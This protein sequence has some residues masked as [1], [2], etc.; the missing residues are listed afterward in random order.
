MAFVNIYSEIAGHV[1]EIPIDLT[2]TL[3]NRAWRDVR[4]KNLWSFLMFEGNWTSPALVNGGTVATTQGRNIVVFDAT[5]TAAINAIFTGGNVPSPVTQR[6]FRIGV[7][8]IY[9]IWAWDG[10]GNATI[11]RPYQEPTA[12]SQTYMIFQCYYYS[13]VMDFWQWI[14]VRDMTN[15]NDLITTK[16]RSEIDAKDPQRTVYYIPTHVV[17]YQQN[18]NPASNQYGI[19]MFE[20]WGV[21]QYVLTYQLYGLRKG[22]PL[23]NDSDTLPPQ[24]GEDCVIELG[25]AKAYEWAE[26][27][28]KG[29]ARGNFIALKQGAM[30]EYRRLFQE[31]RMQDRAMIDNFRTKLRRK[32]SYPNSDGWYSSIAGVASPGAPW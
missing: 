13:P 1:P 2:K 30:V 26:A 11:D 14:T 5:A 19:P 28:S 25:K 20:L 29:R 27:N 22:T 32:W 6:Q 10:N 7:G 16:Q 17:P 3:A 9:N 15:W 4:R 23:V 31:Y 18:Q 8:T 12:S 24:V 21:P